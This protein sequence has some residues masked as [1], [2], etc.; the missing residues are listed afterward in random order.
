MSVGTVEVSL[1]MR[2]AST[3][4]RSHHT[5][6]TLFLGVGLTALALNP[7]TPEHLA[8]A[9]AWITGMA[10]T[11]HSELILGAGIVGLA[12]AVVMILAA[13]LPRVAGPSLLAL[14][15]LGFVTLEW[16]GRALDWALRRTDR[17]IED[18]H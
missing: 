16:P 4:S 13:A 8:G 6:S 18:L 5:L 14:A 1:P 15:S 2:K 7:S 3:V 10:G 17:T 12:A 9:W 11:W